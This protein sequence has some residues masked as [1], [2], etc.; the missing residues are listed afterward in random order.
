TTTVPPTTEAAQAP[1]RT[2]SEP[3]YVPPVAPAP[4]PA[5][6]PLIPGLPQIQLP[7]IQLPPPP[8]IE[9]PRF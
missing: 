6:P 2:Y 7:Q 5:P 8:V 4:A 9:L 1:A 3:E